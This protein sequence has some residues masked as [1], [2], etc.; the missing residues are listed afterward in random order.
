MVA[1]AAKPGGKDK[2]KCKHCLGVYTLG[3]TRAKAHLAGEKGM[4][5][6]VCNSAP[7][8]VR[9]SLIAERQKEVQGKKKAAVSA[10]LDAMTRTTGYSMAGK[11]LSL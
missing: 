11:L 8:D 2:Y 4:G 3:I 10:K 1:A 7:A 9:A 5:V 6:A